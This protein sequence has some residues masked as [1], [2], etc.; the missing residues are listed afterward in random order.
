MESLSRSLSMNRRS[1]PNAH[2]K[3]SLAMVAIFAIS[4]PARAEW[5]GDARP[6]MGTEVSVRLWHD[7]V[8]A[9]EQ[10]IE[11]VFAEAERIDR[12]M[13]TYKEDSRISEINRLAAS[14][15]VVAGE[16][17]RTATLEQRLDPGNFLRIHRGAIVNVDE[18]VAVEHLPKG[19]QLLVL[20]DGTRCRVSRS[21]KQ[22]VDSVLLPG[23][24]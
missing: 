7:D 1:T 20:S 24:S 6:L 17:L 21:R 10:I 15:P 8:A 14:E 4:I 16:E 22:V 5:V 13:S 9:G 12:L 2:M 18:V 19:A 3:L 11:E 23:L